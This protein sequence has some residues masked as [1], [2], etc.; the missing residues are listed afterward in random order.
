M[1][2]LIRR[3]LGLDKLDQLSHQISDVQYRL[4][5]LSLELLEPL[6]A[7][8][9]VLLSEHSQARQDLSKRLGDSVQKT[10]KAE[11]LARRQTLGEL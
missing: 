10:M 4:A 2:N 3:W 1:R 5:N 9:T 8:A 7:V 6:N 11:A